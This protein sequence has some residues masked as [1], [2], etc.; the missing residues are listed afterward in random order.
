MSPIRLGRRHSLL[1]RYN[2][3]NKNYGEVK[4]K[5]LAYIKHTQIG[6]TA[7]VLPLSPGM[8]QKKKSTD[9]HAPGATP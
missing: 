7:H 5:I 4:T 6:T 9:E 3:H 8:G 1:A 2:L